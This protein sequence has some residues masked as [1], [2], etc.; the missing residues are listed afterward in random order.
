MATW[1]ALTP[2]SATV[3]ERPLSVAALHAC[4]RCALTPAGRSRALR[5]Q[6]WCMQDDCNCEAEEE[7]IVGASGWSEYCRRSCG[8]CTPKT[9][10]V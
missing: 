1:P 8:L 9:R 2:W 10:P 4:T 3:L 6:W 7:R 5:T